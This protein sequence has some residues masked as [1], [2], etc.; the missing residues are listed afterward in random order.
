MERVFRAR[1]RGR[2]RSA[3]FALLCSLLLAGS[4]SPA[5]AQADAPE[6]RLHLEAEITPFWQSRNRAGVPG[7]TGTRFDLRDLTGS[8][9]F[10]TGRVSLEWDLRPKHRLQLLAAPLEISAQGTLD[11]PVDFRGVRFAA[12]TTTKATYRF[13]TYRIGYRYRLFDRE[14]W[15]LRIG[16]TGLL[17]DAEIEL[18]QAGVRQ[19]ES[20]VGFVPLLHLD[21]DLELPG[22]FRLKGEFDGFGVPAG[23]AFDIAVKAFYDLDPRWSLG[24]GYRSLEGGSDG[25]TV[26]TF[27]WLHFAV[28]SL[29]VGF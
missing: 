20:N 28:L 9:P 14:R 19:S 12:G 4:S 8:G 22:R 7:D 27:A 13:S 26:Y 25:S 29:R 5:L 16:L 10:L 11:R 6:P 18:A 3:G 21:G 15:Q 17:R 24:L 23:R 2:G 1:G